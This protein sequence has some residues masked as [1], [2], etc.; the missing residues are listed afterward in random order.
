MTT[1]ERPESTRPVRRRRLP[2]KVRRRRFLGT[3]ANHALLIAASLM[4]VLPI[5]WIALT[6]LMTEEQAMTAQLIPDPVQWS[7][8]VTVFQQIDLWRYTWNT[9]LLYTSPSP[10]D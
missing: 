6:S 10:R 5:V 1:A 3:I 8:F 4:F 9:C 7:N 2:A